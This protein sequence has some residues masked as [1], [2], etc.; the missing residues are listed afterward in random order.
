ME[1]GDRASARRGTRTIDGT[2][3]WK[4]M[5]KD[6]SWEISSCLEEN[7]KLNS[8]IDAR[9]RERE[10]KGNKREGGKREEGKKKERDERRQGRLLIDFPFTQLL[11]FGPPPRGRHEAF[12]LPLSYWRGGSAY[13]TSPFRCHH[14]LH[15]SP[16]FPSGPHQGFDLSLPFLTFS[17]D[18]RQSSRPPMLFNGHAVANGFSPSPP[19]VFLLLARPFSSLTL[20]TLPRCPT[21][22]FEHLFF[23]PH[24]SI[25][26]FFPSF[27]PP[28]FSPMVKRY[29]RWRVRDHRCSISSSDK[30]TSVDKLRTGKECN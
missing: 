19:P 14:P 5:E 7:R 30:V 28:S 16:L 8:P 15:P 2:S 29:R 25:S 11:S 22:S 27:L 10:I 1:S 4:W 3:T 13:K 17:P 6:E 20:S 24:P 26:P 21:S 18:P 12:Q 23:S 9:E